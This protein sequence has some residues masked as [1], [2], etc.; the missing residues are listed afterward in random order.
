MTRPAAPRIRAPEAA[1]MLGVTL[2]GL[3]AL[4]ARGALPGAAKICTL[5]TFDVKKLKRF[6]EMRDSVELAAVNDECRQ[7]FAPP[8]NT[9]TKNH[10]YV[11]G[12]DNYIKIGW[13]SAP[14]G[15]RLKT[16]QTG[17]PMKLIDYGELLG[18]RHLEAYLHDRFKAYR[19]EGEW[20]RKRGAIGKWISAGCPMPKRYSP[21]QLVPGCRRLSE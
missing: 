7:M 13:S 3:Q 19:L 10:I 11:V 20:F 15:E 18:D 2:R 17:S 8:K 14:R 9:D 1:A 5:W 6:A 4:A 21:S 16:L 12:Y